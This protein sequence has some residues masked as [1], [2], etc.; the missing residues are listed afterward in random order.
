LNTFSEQWQGHVVEASGY[1]ELGML[2]EAAKTLQEIRAEDESRREVLG[3]R[4]DL[5]MAARKW[6]LAAKFARRLVENEPGNAGAWVNLAY[7]IRRLEGLD[8]AEEILLHALS[9]HPRHAMIAYNLACYA[10][11]AG[12]SEEAK[13]RLRQAFDLDRS[14]RVVALEDPDLRPLWDWVKRSESQS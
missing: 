8:A 7:S 4:L 12:R 3:V 1:I 9:L 13:D 11:V 5:Y 14:F 6:D 10:S 2:E